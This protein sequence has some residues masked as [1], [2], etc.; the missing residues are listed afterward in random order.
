MNKWQEKSKFKLLTSPK[1]LNKKFIFLSTRIKPNEISL[2]NYNFHVDQILELA[3]PY[4]HEG[5]IKVDSQPSSLH[6]SYFEPASPCAIQDIEAKEVVSD[7]DNTPIPILARLD[8]VFAL[9]NK[10][11]DTAIHYDNPPGNFVAGNSWMLE[12]LDQSKINH[13]DEAL[14]QL[15]E[16]QSLFTYYLSQS[17]S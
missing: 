11:D 7:E 5:S 13:E 15:A 16:Q 8:S 3:P 10:L 1:D 9:N 4:Q 6:S 2:I 14:P 17:L 12:N